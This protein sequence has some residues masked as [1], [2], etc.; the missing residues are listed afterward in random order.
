M[1]VNGDVVHHVDGY[2]TNEENIDE[3]VDR[4][5]EMM[6]GVEDELGER[7]LVFD[8]LTEASQMPLYPECTKFTE[9]TDV[10]TIFNI[11]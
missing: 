10:L 6:E 8:L 1:D 2:E 9:L 4:V 11:K 5:D 7:P 3:D